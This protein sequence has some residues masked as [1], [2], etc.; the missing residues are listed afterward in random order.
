M[1]C[2]PLFAAYTL[3][4]LVFH[5]VSYRKTVNIDIVYIIAEGKNHVC[6]KSYNNV[7]WSNGVSWTLI[8]GSKTL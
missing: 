4:K 7:I 3:K 6:V 5:V 8:H 1:D 2:T